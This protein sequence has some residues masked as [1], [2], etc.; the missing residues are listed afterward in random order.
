MRR[1][2][3]WFGVLGL[4]LA[5][6]HAAGAQDV[7]V[8]L[9]V[10][11]TGTVPG[12]PV[13]ATVTVSGAGHS[14]PVELTVPPGMTAH[15]S[16][17][18]RNVQIIN[19]AI[20]SNHQSFFSVVAAE[21]GIYPLGPARVR[22]D[23]RVVSSRQVTVTVAAAGRRAEARTGVFAE[24]KVRDRTPY[25]GEQVMYTLR[26]FRPR[27]QSLRDFRLIE[28]ETTGLWKEE[29]HA[30]ADRVT[31]INNQPYIVHTVQRAYFPTREGAVEIGA[32]GVTYYEVLPRRR[33]RGPRSIFDD[34]FFDAFNQRTAARRVEVAPISLNVRPLPDPP[35]GVAVAD[36]GVGTYAMTATL[37]AD[38]VRVGESL[39]LTVLLTGAGNLRSVPEFT[40]PDGD[41][42]KA[43]PDA[44]TVTVTA[45]GG[46]VRGKREQRI[47]FVPQREGPVTIPPLRL[48]TFDPAAEEWTVL[49]TPAYTVDVQP[50]ESQ[51][52]LLL[53][54]EDA[55]GLR[56]GTT[57][58]APQ[59]LAMDLLAPHPLPNRFRFASTGRGGRTLLG[60]GAPV[61]FLLSWV[62]RRRAAAHA[63]DPTLLRR[64]RAGRAARATLKHHPPP[65]A[66]SIAAV[67]TTYVADRVGAAPGSITGDEA[68]AIIRTAD[69]TLAST[70]AEIIR[71]GEAMRFGG[72]AP[73]STAD[74]AAALALVDALERHAVSRGSVHA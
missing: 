25:L 18:S 61:L 60:I 2:A 19:G 7:A 28:P 4:S 34:S 46:T 43:Y 33:R 70:A 62:A 55:R 22:V 17:T 41:G 10:S 45:E 16:G 66:A 30:D 36:T 38:T 59:R 1:F 21:P 20:E 35:A 32:A 11:S 63:A 12:Q 26:V 51:V 29:I 44:A 23:G 57:A 40:L 13:R 9:D 15:A 6:A 71:A 47:A 50:G 69:A 5:A 64:R 72:N 3:T 53:A 24:A 14:L 39:T 58:A 37:S 42:F 31:T 52:P 56:A 8:R 54:A 74:T 67:V 48:V 68:L 49:T 65:D 73:A 27:T